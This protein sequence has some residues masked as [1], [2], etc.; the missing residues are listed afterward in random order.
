MVQVA[1]VVV[2]PGMAY[3]GIMITPCMV[4]ILRLADC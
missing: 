4:Q 3:M 2:G 1:M